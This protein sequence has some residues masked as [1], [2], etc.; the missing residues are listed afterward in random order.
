[1]LPSVLKKCCQIILHIFKI[2]N[3]NIYLV[4]GWQTV[5]E[6]ICKTGEGLLLHRGR[7]TAIQDVLGT[8][9]QRVIAAL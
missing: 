5:P 4:S 6:R 9:V 2:S 8:T 7:E 3:Y 1:M